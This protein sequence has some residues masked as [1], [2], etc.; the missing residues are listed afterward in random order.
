MAG[1]GQIS[2]WQKKAPA[3]FQTLGRRFLYSL[4]LGILFYVLYERSYLSGY[5]LPGRIDLS[6]RAVSWNTIHVLP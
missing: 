5:Q 3:I 1:L 4:T 2:L 6:R